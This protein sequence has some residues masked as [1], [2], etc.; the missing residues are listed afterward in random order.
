MSTATLVVLVVVAV[1]GVLA[2]GITTL[3]LVQ[4]LKRL[5][6]SLQ[7]LR[8]ELNPSLSQLREDAEVTRRELERVSDAADELRRR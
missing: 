6:V 5:I 7:E 4:H 3:A 1:V 2:L 8:D